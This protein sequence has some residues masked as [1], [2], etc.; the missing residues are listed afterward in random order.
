MVADV[1]VGLF[2]FER[3]AEVSVLATGP[4]TLR[5]GSN[6]WRMKPGAAITFWAAR[7]GIGASWPGH[8]A[9][10][11]RFKLDGPAPWRLSARGGTRLVPAASGLLMTRE[12]MALLPI[13]TLPREAYVAAVS[14]GEMPPNW[15][16]AALEAQAIAA[17][18]YTAARLLARPH[19]GFALCDATHCQRFRGEGASDVRTRTAVDATRDLTLM[20]RGLAAET[21]WSAAC[22]G[23][24]APADDL[25]GR[26]TP[27]YLAGGPDRRPDGTPWCGDTTWRAEASRETLHDALS[28][29]NLMDPAEPLHGLR[30][31]ETGRY[32]HVRTVRITGERPRDVTGPAFWAAVGPRLGWT[33]LRSQHFTLVTSRTGNI[34][35]TGVGLGHGVGMCQAGARARAEAGWSAARILASYF[36]GTVL[37]VSR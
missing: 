35:F 27:A 3:P 11:A 24:R 23:E 33:G 5:S 7:G 32:G 12:N 28:V 31:A 36:P 19:T 8:A 14:A 34:V 15:P 17:R 16:R 20:Y 9:T 10:A 30:V 18:S 22:G 13:A 6:A 29:A 2:H 4:W 1:A 26:G 25:F 21:T 37:T